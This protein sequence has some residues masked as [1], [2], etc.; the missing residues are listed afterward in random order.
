M[1]VWSVVWIV[2]TRYGLT[3]GAA[4]AP[5]VLTA[6][7]FLVAALVPVALGLAP[8]LAVPRPPGAVPSSQMLSGT[9]STAGP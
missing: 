9:A 5:L 8:V 1:P 2:A 7:L 4:H 3:P 6:V